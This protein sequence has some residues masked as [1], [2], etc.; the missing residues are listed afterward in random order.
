VKSS[1]TKSSSTTP[2]FLRYNTI[3]LKLFLEIADTSNHRLLLI[4]GEATDE[5][6]ADQWEKLVE[7][8]NYH[9]GNQ[10]YGN[11][12]IHLDSYRQLMRK[13]ITVRSTLCCL[14][15]VVDN[16]M[17]AWLD[18]EG[19]HLDTTHGQ[20]AY[21]NSL[22][23]AFNKSNNLNSK[24]NQK[25]NQIETFQ[26]AIIME[27]KEFNDAQEENSFEERIAAISFYMRFEV[28]D[29]VLLTRYNSY[30]KKINKEQA[31]IKSNGSRA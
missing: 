4:R 31:Q 11:F 16:D 27:R 1:G 5:Q 14:L 12:L 8:Q 3:T 24:Q 23:R 6:C 20:G 25:L 10:D 26:Q 17:I 19:Y 22:Q 9:C 7:Q 21:L 29:N 15:F 28:D 13:F 30:V 2:D 18:K